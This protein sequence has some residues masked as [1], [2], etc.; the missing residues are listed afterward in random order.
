MAGP[1]TLN[2]TAFQ[3]SPA[4]SGT[5]GGG[6]I[7]GGS[8][9][10]VLTTTSA[11]NTVT[12]QGNGNT[13]TAPN[14]LVS[15]QL[16]DANLKLIGADWVTITGFTMQENAANTTT[17]PGSNDMIEWGIALL[18]AST[19]D[20]A[21]NDTIQNNTINLNRTYLN[22]YGIYANATHSPTAPTGSAGATGLAGGN[23]GLEVY[24]NSISNVN[25]GIVVVGTT[26][27]ADANTLIDIGGSG[28]VQA[29]SITNFGTGIPTTTFTNVSGT[30][31]GI[32]VRNTNGFNISYNTITSSA[33]GTI[34]GTLNGI[35]IPSASNAPTG[36]FTNSINN[37]TISLQTSTTSGAINGIPLPSSS[38]SATATLNVNGNNFTGFGY[39]T[40]NFGT[41][42]FITNSS[43]YQTQSISNNT[44]TNNSVNTSSTV[45]IISN[46]TNLPTGGTKNVNGN[47]IVGTFSKSLAGGTL[48]FFSD[49]GTDAAGTTNNTNNNNFS[50]IT[51]TGAT[52]FN[53]FL[54]SN[55]SPNKIVSNNPIGNLRAGSQIPFRPSVLRSIREQRRS[56]VISFPI[57]ALQAEP[58]PESF[59]VE[60]QECRP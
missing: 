49:N 2:V 10:L 31:N 54:D 25:V 53:G 57:L 26:A 32:L 13:V 3:T 28:G 17:T 15:G 14:N 37:N 59:A 43:N 18:Y 56:A 5:T 58:L 39:P 23:T 34:T 33:G 50:N 42:N 47:S 44:F 9:S 38:A 41:V 21:Q 36:T 1:V 6:Y 27:A 8:G 4:N 22:S 24:G 51:I 11:T 52:N 55:A 7:I 35:Q 45:I 16:N 40:D 48:T 46:G 60:R 30:V 12:I 20:G 29:N 19:T